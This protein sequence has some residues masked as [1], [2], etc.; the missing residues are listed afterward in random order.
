[1]KRI[2]WLVAFVVI[3]LCGIPIWACLNY[4]AAIAAEK[5]RYMKTCQDAGHSAK[6]CELRWYERGRE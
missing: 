2:E 5:A 6:E 4:P 3:V 1:V